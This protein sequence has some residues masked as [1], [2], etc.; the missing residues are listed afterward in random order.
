MQKLTYS[1][2]TVITISLL[3]LTSCST[4]VEE[5]EISLK[6]DNIT[7]ELTQSSQKTTESTQSTPQIYDVNT[8]SPKTDEVKQK[9]TS[10]LKDSLNESSKENNN[11]A[12]LQ[13][14]EKLDPNM[15]EAVIS[16][17]NDTRQ[18]TLVTPINDSD[19]TRVK[20]TVSGYNETTNSIE[21]TIVVTVDGNYSV[22]QIDAN[23][24]L[25]DQAE[26]TVTFET[27]SGQTLFS[28]TY[29]K[30]NWNNTDVPKL[31]ESPT[32]NSCYWDCMANYGYTFSGWQFAYSTT[33]L[34]STGGFMSSGPLGALAG[35]ST[36]L[37]VHT[38]CGWGC[39]A[40]W[41]WFD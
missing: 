17:D 22:A 14:P 33:L 36:T 2:S 30:Q 8:N 37:G 4:N 28:Q 34:G 41:I 1:I 7:A 25:A 19:N 32:M 31:G 6:G 26:V 40:S 5:E 35:L 9:L 23:P 12:N 13:E 38:G 21:K 11:T 16:E 29:T 27:Q 39:F 18:Q 15:D 3:I 20:A 24:Q 10:I